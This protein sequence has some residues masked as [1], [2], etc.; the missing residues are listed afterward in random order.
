MIW[1]AF[2]LGACGLFGRTSVVRVDLG[3]QAGEVGLGLTEMDAARSEMIAVGAYEMGRFSDRD[4]KTL[5]RSLERNLESAESEA[6]L[7]VHVYI[8]S[9]VITASNNAGWAL[10]SVAWCL[11]APDGT[12]AFQEQVYVAS[13]GRLVVT[14]GKVKERLMRRLV[15]RVGGVSLHLARGGSPEGLPAMPEGVSHTPEGAA[16]GLPR[17]LQSHYIFT[18]GGYVWSGRSDAVVTD[19]ASTA[20]TDVFDWPAHLAGR[21]SAAVTAR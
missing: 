12:V 19:P 3:A 20:I 7:D 2:T 8:R 9:F 15:E 21:P 14:I 4:L 18:L 16:V 10:A 17:V 6:A 13:K 11:T 5:R 1:I